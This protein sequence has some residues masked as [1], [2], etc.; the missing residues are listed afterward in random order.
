ME[1]NLKFIPIEVA[2]RIKKLFKS[3]AKEYIKLVYEEE[4]EDDEICSFGIFTDSDIS[5]YFF[6]YN[7]KEGLEEIIEEGKAYKREFPESKLKVDDLKWRLP[8]WTNGVDDECFEEDKREIEIFEILEKQISNT[9]NLNRDE[10][11]FS[12]YKD[13]IFD[14]FCETLLELKKENVFR[15]VS[16]DFFLIVQVADSSMCRNKNR[17]KSLS[18]ILNQQQISELKRFEEVW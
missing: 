6:G 9:R 17:L 18:R 10:N 15:Q 7:T 14:I 16:K 5:N 12:D 1:N 11:C 8:E 2:D 13:D 4:E 3:L